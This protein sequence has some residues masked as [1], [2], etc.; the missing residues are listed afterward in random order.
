MPCSTTERAISRTR[1][2]TTTT[3]TT[4]PPGG[5]GWGGGDVLDTSD[6]HASTG[7]STESRL[8]TGAGGLCAVTT[9]SPDLDVEGRDAEFLAAGS[10]S[11]VSFLPFSL[12]LF[13]FYAPT[14]WAANMAAY[15]EDSSRSALTFIPPVILEMVSRPERSVT[16]TKLQMSVYRSFSIRQSCKPTY[17]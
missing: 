15:G 13:C 4:L 17:R 3:A 16:W 7:K 11:V 9:S 14:S 8:G 6:A 2:E 10:C 5:V 1:S 12:R